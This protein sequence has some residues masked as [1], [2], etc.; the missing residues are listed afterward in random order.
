MTA[1][2]TAIVTYSPIALKP[3]PLSRVCPNIMASRQPFTPSEIENIRSF[4][5]EQQMDIIHLPGL[6]RGKTAPW[7]LANLG[8][9]RYNAAAYLGALAAGWQWAT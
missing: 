7:D 2:N 6:P 4:A 1:S 9:N 5:L 8:V 3:V